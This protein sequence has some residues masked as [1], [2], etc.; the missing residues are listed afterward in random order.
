M[1]KYTYKDYVKL[2]SFDVGGIL[3]EL[4]NGV[5]QMVSAPKDIHQELSSNISGELYNFIKKNKKDCKLRFSPYDVYLK[6]NIILQPDISIIC[7]LDKISKRGCNGIPDLIV[8]ILS[9]GTKRNDLPGGSK[10]NIYQEFLLQE[11]W[12]VDPLD[13]ENITLTQF[14]LEDEILVQKQIYTKN[15]KI[16]SYIFPDLE[17]DLKEIFE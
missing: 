3:W 13:A 15:D 7:E 16:T 1:I 12:I 4:I 2:P 17:I 14:V 6:D 8:E 5:I 10:F 9:E 11:Y